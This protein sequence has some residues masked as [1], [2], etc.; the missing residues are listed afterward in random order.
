[1]MWDLFIVVYL[2][3]GLAMSIFGNWVFTSGGKPALNPREFITITVFWWMVVAF[4]VYS[5]L[6]G[7]D[8]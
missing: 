7:D 3:A 5:I 6:K 4:F 1:M 8:L 2:A